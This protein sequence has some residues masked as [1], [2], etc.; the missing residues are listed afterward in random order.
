MKEHA[1]PKKK[2]KTKMNDDNNFIKA[3]TLLHQFSFHIYSC[4][5]L[6]KNQDEKHVSIKFSC[7]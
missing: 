4:R 6:F 3:P 2:N 5:L 1:F 7:A